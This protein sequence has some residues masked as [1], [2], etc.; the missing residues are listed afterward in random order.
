MTQGCCGSHFRLHADCWC[1][2]LVCWARRT[3]LLLISTTFTPQQKEEKNLTWAAEF[4]HWRVEW[5]PCRVLLLNVIAQLLNYI[6]SEACQCPEKNFAGFQWAWTWLVPVA[7]QQGKRSQEIIPNVGPLLYDPWMC[8]CMEFSQAFYC[9][10]APSC[11]WIVS[12]AQQYQLNM[13]VFWFS[14]AVYQPGLT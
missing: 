9:S 13:K 14:S 4:Y 3:F 1:A 6:C 11:L 5:V 10:L 12:F 2:V 7:S 8:Q